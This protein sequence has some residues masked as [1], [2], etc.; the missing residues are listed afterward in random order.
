MT[1]T[2]EIVAK[3]WQ[4]VC[5]KVGAMVIKLHA[6]EKEEAE[7]RAELARM[8]EIGIRLDHSAHWANKVEQAI[9]QDGGP[10]FD[11]SVK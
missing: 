6:L 4:A 1:K 8:S 2:E 10:K 3:E 5:A 9:E 11:P 7:L